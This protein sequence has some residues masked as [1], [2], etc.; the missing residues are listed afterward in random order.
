MRFHWKS[1]AVEE[2]VGEPLPDFRGEVWVGEEEY[3]PAVSK[4]VWQICH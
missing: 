2:K 3:G 1:P 4:V